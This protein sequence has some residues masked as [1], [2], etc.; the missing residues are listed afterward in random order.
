MGQETEQLAA[1]NSEFEGHLIAAQHQLKY[2]EAEIAYDRVLNQV[3]DDLSKA[4]TPEEAQSI[5][6]RAR[7]QFQQVLAPYQTDKVMSRILGIHDQEQDVEL[8]SVVNAKKAQIIGIQD[9]AANAVKKTTT[10]QE[11]INLGSAGQDWTKPR[12]Q[13]EAWLHASA[14]TKTMPPE[15]IAHDMLEWDVAVEAGN[16]ETKLGSENL[17][18][19]Q[20]TL[21]D[22]RLHPN[23]YPHLD[24][25][26][27]NAYIE[28][29][30]SAIVARMSRQDEINAKTEEHKYWN[31]DDPAALPRLATKA[32]GDY[33]QT[34]ADKY[35]SSRGLSPAGEK[36]LLEASKVHAAGANA[37]LDQQASKLG[38][39]IVAAGQ[40][41][42][43]KKA[44]ELLDQFK[45]LADQHPDLSAA[46][47]GYA[48]F[49]DARIHEK[50]SL[51]IQ[52]ATLQN[53]KER[54]EIQKD[55]QYSFDTLGQIEL[56]M[57]QNKHYSD[58]E[59]RAMAGRGKGKM[60]TAQVTA[61]I[62]LS[63]AVDKD[64]DNANYFKAI[65]SYIGTDNPGLL[66]KVTN[67]FSAYLRE[68]PKATSDQKAAFVKHLTD[69]ENTDKLSTAI[70]DAAEKLNNSGQ[71]VQTP[72][73]RI[74]KAID[75]MNAPENTGDDTAPKRTPKVVERRTTPS[76]KKLEKLDDG[77]IR[78]AK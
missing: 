51:A 27:I 44:S 29:G 77:T 2:K 52:S 20:D 60:S 73:N 47:K 7:A 58:T 26:Q 66:G 74:N 56:D 9:A 8:Q 12:A 34:L 57:S 70:D 75:E 6:D 36:K 35:I 63:H 24:Q 49:E 67:D 15:V 42:D 21:T 32:N 16:I 48:T 1:A 40:H 72:D 17:Q 78:E 31:P 76:G 69:T 10:E 68:N 14:L 55:Q 62:E 3:H 43:A 19:V 37:E 64:P 4:S 38:N 41:G 54:L 50:M 28:K 45:Q 71:S 33:D 65:N 59:L 53:D 61:A 13:Y 22:L 23:K 25:A 18:V 39:D 46:Y 30:D 5:K 11:A